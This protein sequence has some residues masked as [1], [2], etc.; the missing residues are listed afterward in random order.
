M[1]TEHTTEARLLIQRLT[2]GFC[3]I[4]L[5]AVSTGTLLRTVLSDPN[6]NWWVF[7]FTAGTLGLL[8]V[9]FILTLKKNIQRLS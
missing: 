9:F 4:I 3:I 5:L 6:P 2:T 8:C 7:S 1:T